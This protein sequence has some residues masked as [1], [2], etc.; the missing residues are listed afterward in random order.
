MWE[1][2]KF[3]APKS[4]KFAGTQKTANTLPNHDGMVDPSLRKPAVLYEIDPKNRKHPL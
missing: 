4:L 3:W 2:G 1:V